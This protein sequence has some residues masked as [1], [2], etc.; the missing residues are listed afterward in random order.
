MALS[1]FSSIGKRKLGVHVLLIIFTI[2]ALAFAVRVNHFQ[3][4]YFMADLFPLGLAVTTLVIL[5]FTLVLDVAIKNIPTARPAVEVG[6]LYV[7]SIFWLAFN[8]FST[9][10]WSRIPMSCGSIPDEY[11]D[12]RGWC[13]DV[14]AL[15]SFVWIEFVAIFFAASWILRYALSEHK[16]GHQHIWGGPLSR[17]RPHEGAPNARLTFTDYFAPVRGHQAFEKF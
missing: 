14:Q 15:K 5:I 4:Y 11:A 7:L 10:R 3:E 16:Q 1:E 2:L 6:L 8:A 13:R 9:S 17:Y 12:M